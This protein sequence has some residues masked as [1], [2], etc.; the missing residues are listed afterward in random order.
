[1]FNATS[2]LNK[3][4]RAGLALAALT[5]GLIGV[6][7]VAS[8]AVPDESVRAITVSYSDLNLASDQGSKVLYARIVSAAR[9]VCG[10]NDVDARDLHALALEQACETRAVAQAVQQVNM[11]TL[12]ALHSAH[13]TRG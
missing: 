1:M 7:G 2:K 11:P 8:A 5:A 13:L 9:A 12:A 3:Y 4:R 10:A 6:T